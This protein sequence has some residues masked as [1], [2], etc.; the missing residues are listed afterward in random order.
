[1]ARL[2]LLLLIR[3]AAHLG[4]APFQAIPDPPHGVCHDTLHRTNHRAIALLLYL[5]GRLVER[6]ATNRAIIGSAHLGS[7]PFLRFAATAPL[8]GQ[9]KASAFRTA[10]HEEDVELRDWV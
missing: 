5:Q 10:F 6:I 4:V 3:E 1:M 7:H 9:H 2:Q 8:D